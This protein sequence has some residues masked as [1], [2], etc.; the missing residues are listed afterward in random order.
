M[1]WQEEHCMMV[2]K[3]FDDLYKK[4][5]D[6]NWSIVSQTDSTF[7]GELK[8]EIGKNHFFYHQQIQAVAKCDSNDDVLFLVTGDNE[9]KDDYYIFHLTYSGHGEENL[10]YKRFDGIESVKAYIE[11]VYIEEYL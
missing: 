4:Y 3:V 8:R 9:K 6:F 10:K 2:E 7:V 1:F 11:K 5:E